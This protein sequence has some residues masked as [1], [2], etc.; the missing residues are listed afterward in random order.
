M[1]PLSSA[2][3][4]TILKEQLVTK[5]EIL[6]DYVKQGGTLIT[7]YT[8]TYGLLTDKIS[9]IEMRLS[10]NR[11]TDEEAKVEFI[12]PEHQV[13]NYPNK[14]TAQDFEG[15]IQERGLYF[16]DKWSEDFTPI[17]KIQDYDDEPTYGSLLIAEYGKGYYIYTG[18]GFFRQLPAGVPGAFRLMSNLL[19]IQADE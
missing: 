17:F 15:W 10:R 1:K 11:V 2:F 9:P 14:I 18:L 8:T 13:L 3:V 7:Q 12:N 6:F 16:P 19:S 4:P 5:N